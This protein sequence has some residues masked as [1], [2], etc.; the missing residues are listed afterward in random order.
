MIPGYAIVEW[1]D[2]GIQLDV[3]DPKLAAIEKNVTPG[4]V[5]VSCQDMLTAWKKKTKSGTTDKLIHALEACDYI[6]DAAVIKKG[7][8]RLASLLCCK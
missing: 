8:I 5:V 4:N 1:K 2:L 6:A 7:L 3:E